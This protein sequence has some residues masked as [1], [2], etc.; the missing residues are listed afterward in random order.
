MAEFEDR[1]NALLS[2]PNSM[3]QI[4]QLAQSL[5]GGGTQNAP[6]PRQSAPPPPPVSAPPQG[7]NPL[8]AL[9]GGVDPAALARLLPLIQ[10]LGA[11]QNGNSR[12]LLY[13]IKPYL[14]PAR[15][16]KVERAL[17][18]ARVVH[19]GKKFISGWEA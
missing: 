10:E 3:A 19:V 8:S 5:G 17:Q 11:P 15:Q 2:D 9:L 1:L 14:K 7:G 18:L 4:L 16:E 6:P 13:A 12:A